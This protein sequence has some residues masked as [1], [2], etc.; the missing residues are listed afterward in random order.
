[1][2]KLNFKT[3][4]TRATLGELWCMTVEL[5]NGTDDQPDVF[6]AQLRDTWHQTG[7]STCTWRLDCV[8]RDLLVWLADE[9]DYFGDTSTGWN[10][11]VMRT[12]RA[13]PRLAREIRALIG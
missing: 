10:D 1:M 13:F 9:L 4:A 7:R 12:R 3:R 8:S 6:R 2:S 11:E 5:S